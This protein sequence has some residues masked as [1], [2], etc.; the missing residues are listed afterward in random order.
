[1]TLFATG[2]VFGFSVCAVAVAFEL[3]RQS[4]KGNGKL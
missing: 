2:F 1:M 3:R 4:F